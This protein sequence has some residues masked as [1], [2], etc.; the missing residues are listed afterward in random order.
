MTKRAKFIIE[1]DLETR[2]WERTSLRW[3][4]PATAVSAS[5]RQR[6]REK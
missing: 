6:G 3:K 2:T 4:C 5:Y 1:L